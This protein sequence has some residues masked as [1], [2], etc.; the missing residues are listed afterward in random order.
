[1]LPERLNLCHLTRLPRPDIRAAVCFVFFL[2]FLLRFGVLIGKTSDEVANI[3]YAMTMFCSE[4]LT[5]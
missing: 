3:A 5:G 2:V 1:M 4:L